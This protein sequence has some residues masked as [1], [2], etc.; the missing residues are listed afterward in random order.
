MGTKHVV[1]SE[2]AHDSDKER[3]ESGLERKTEFRFEL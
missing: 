3:E 2:V 1:I